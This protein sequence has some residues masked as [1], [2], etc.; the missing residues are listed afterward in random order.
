MTEFECHGTR[1][2]YLGNITDIPY[3]ADSGHTRILQLA[4]LL[5]F[6]AGRYFNSRD[7]TYLDIILNRIDKPSPIR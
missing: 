5:D 3:F 7:T 4:D 2:G 1:Y 6:A